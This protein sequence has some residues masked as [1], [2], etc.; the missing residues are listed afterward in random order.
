MER[1][2]LPLKAGKRESRE[3]QVSIFDHMEFQF[4]PLSLLA[5]PKLKVFAAL[6]CLAAWGPLSALAV[7]GCDPAPTRPAA[8]VIAAGQPL[9][10]KR[11]RLYAA[12]HTALGATVCAGWAQAP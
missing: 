7:A 9:A 6:P 5:E 11:D 2:G 4:P 1:S 10:A 12:V 8:D 3:A